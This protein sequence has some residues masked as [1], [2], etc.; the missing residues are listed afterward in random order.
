MATYSEALKTANLETVDDPAERR[1]IRGQ[2][3]MNHFRAY[4]SNFDAS[5]VS[6][7]NM[8]MNTEQN[9][10]SPVDLRWYYAKPK[11]AVHPHEVQHIDK[12]VHALESMFL[13]GLCDV[14]EHPCLNNGACVD[15]Q[16]HCAI[17]SFGAICQVPPTGNGRC[18][19]GFDIPKYGNDGG[20]CC[21]ST[22]ISGDFYH[23]GKDESGFVYLG[24]FIRKR[25]IFDGIIFGGQIFYVLSFVA[26][27]GWFEWL[28]FQFHLQNIGRTS[29][30]LYHHI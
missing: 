27:H 16:C 11:V 9:S 13:C 3:F 29:G 12:F 5:F 30:W 6:E 7:P 25:E 26:L 8:D 1:R 15:R 22:F 20:D 18:D 10:A 2:Y 24:Y 28:S 4:W 19:A 17:G 14:G 21:E 23:S